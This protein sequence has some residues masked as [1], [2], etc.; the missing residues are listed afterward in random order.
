MILFSYKTI[1]AG[2]LSDFEMDVTKKT[3]KTSSPSSENGIQ[4]QY[5]NNND[6]SISNESCLG[7]CFISTCEDL[8]FKILGK[9][10]QTIDE[11]NRSIYYK[12]YPYFSGPD[13]IMTKKNTGK[14]YFIDIGLNYVYNINKNEEKIQGINNYVYLNYLSRF[15]FY[16][17]H[18]ILYGNDTLAFV[19]INIFGYDF[20]KLSFLNLASYAGIKILKG[21]KSNSAFN[22]GI[23]IIIFPGSYL[24]LTTQYDIST[25]ENNLQE[26][27]IS[28]GFFINR[29][30][31]NICYKTLFSPNYTLN[32]IYT[33]ISFWI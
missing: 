6:K 3:N 18:L 24:N 4:I 30:H 31:I 5:F 22:W 33:G 13:I 17:D 2:I 20:V 11:Y 28:L 23:R 27:F 9:S 15:V 14:Q 7:G 25:F 12:K 21:K 10:L 19:G 1:Y 26:F 32:N 29:F 16:F 8:I